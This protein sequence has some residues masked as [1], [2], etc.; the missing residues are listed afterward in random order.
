MVSQS[1]GADADC[2]IAAVVQCAFK[3][4]HGRQVNGIVENADRGFANAFQFLVGIN[5]GQIDGNEITDVNQ[6]IMAGLDDIIILVKGFGRELCRADIAVRFRTEVGADN[7][8]VVLIGV[9]A[10]KRVFERNVR[11][12]GFNLRAHELFKQFFGREEFGHFQLAEFGVKIK[13]VVDF[14]K[15]CAPE[16]AEFNAVFFTDFVRVNQ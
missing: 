8:A 3:N 14:F 1:H 13:L 12:A 15:L 7:N 16:I 5:E 4:W 9:I 11:H 10:V 6:A 2:P